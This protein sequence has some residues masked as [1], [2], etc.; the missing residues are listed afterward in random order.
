MI[1]GREEI[2]AG[3]GKEG[4]ERGGGWGWGS[5]PK[6]M[7]TWVLPLRTALVPTSPTS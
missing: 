6:K 1:V 7:A 2:N 5:G 4:A 3:V